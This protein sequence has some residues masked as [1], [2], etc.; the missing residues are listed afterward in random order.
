MKK[1]TILFLL[2]FAGI[3]TSQAQTAYSIYAAPGMYSISSE[4]ADQSVLDKI[5]KET[6]EIVES[7]PLYNIA[8]DIKSKLNERRKHY[9]KIRRCEDREYKIVFN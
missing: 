9:R 5:Q 1:I 4:Q 3:S 7:H 6:R 8:R 2:A